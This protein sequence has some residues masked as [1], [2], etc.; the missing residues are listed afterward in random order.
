[1]NKLGKRNNIGN[2]LFIINGDKIHNG[3]FCQATSPFSFAMR[4]PSIFL[5]KNNPASFAGM[6]SVHP[7]Y[8][9]P[10]S[11]LIYEKVLT[12]ASTEISFEKR[13]LK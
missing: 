7:R 11:D 2:L 12:K 5:H 6:R 4:A 13:L 9:F 8:Q 10:K 3:D 1:M